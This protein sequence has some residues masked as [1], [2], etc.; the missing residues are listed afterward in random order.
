M[1]KHE[2]RRTNVKGEESSIS[3]TFLSPDAKR[4]H[5][6]AT[7]CLLSVCHIATEIR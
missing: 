4:Q 2:E 5:S 3:G 6:F 7:G 1:V